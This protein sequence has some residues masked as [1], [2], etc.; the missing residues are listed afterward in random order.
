MQPAPAA[1]PVKSNKLTIKQV[2]ELRAMFTCYSTDDMMTQEQL[3]TMFANIGFVPTASQKEKHAKLF[4]IRDKISCTEFMSI[5]K[6]KPEDIPF[7]K[8]EVLNAFK[9]FLLN[10]TPHSFYHKNIKSHI[11]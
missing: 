7:S 10:S 3:N 8:T 1:P 5:F 4:A 11:I 6:I 9:V 2:E